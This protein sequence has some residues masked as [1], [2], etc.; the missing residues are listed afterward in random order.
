MENVIKIKDLSVG[1]HA[2][3]KKNEIVKSISFDVPKGKTVAL[4]GESGSGKTIT[5]LSILKLLPYPTAFHSSGEIIYENNNLLNAKQKEIQKIRGKK[6]TAIF[7]EPMTSLN[8]LHTIQKQINEIIQIHSKIS[9]LEASDQ[10]KKLLKIVG[11]ENI[12]KRPNAYPHE[13]SGGQRQRVMIAM[14]IAN[15]PDLLIADEPTT[16][17]DVS[18]QSQI[19]ELI[20]NLQKKMNMSILFIS[21]D[22]SVVKKIADYVC[23][24][25]DGKIVEQN[26]KKEIFENPQNEYTKLLIRSQIKNKETKFNNKKNILNVKELKVWFPIK[27]G[28]LRRVKGYVKAVDSLNFDLKLK[29]TLGVVGESGSGKTSLV[30]AILKLITSKGQIIFNNKDINFID[31]QEMKKLRKEMQ[32]V[33]QDPFS[34]LSPRMTIEQIIMEG[35]EI[36]ETK[37]TKKE[38]IEEII[39]ITNEVGLNYNEISQRFPHEFSGGQRQRIAIARSLVLKPKLLILDEPTSSLDVSM[40]NQI[41]ELLNNLQEKYNLSYI[42]ISHNMKVIQAMSD[43]IIVMKNGKI[44]EEGEKNIIFNNPISDYTKELLQSI[45]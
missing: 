24:M 33:F 10:T 27:K 36:H 35:I 25:K 42:F 3:D 37:K 34:S 26:I 32:I 17:L 1:F 30:L 9:N 4:V 43:Y 15:K 8:P 44:I 22:L 19:L 2:Q 21:H 41:L 18:I 29:Q 16:A 39:N 23:I 28:L 31:N 12:S 45:I 6:I 13:L 14:S 11:L 5:A 20:M 38:K 7:Q 40:Q